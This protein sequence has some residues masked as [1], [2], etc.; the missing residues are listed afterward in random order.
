MSDTDTW[1]SACSTAD[2]EPG[3]GLKVPGT[4]PPIAVFNI[5]GEY[6]AI[7][8]TCSHAEYSLAEGYV[9][10]DTVECELHYAA[11][12]VK[13]GAALT[14]PATEPVGTYSVRV[15]DDQ[16]QVAAT[17]RCVIAESRL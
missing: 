5:D 15:H 16:I 2:L 7:D 17:Q 14:A 11:F 4:C 12:S 1:I 10:G 9:D 6:F 13:T 3:T 8:D